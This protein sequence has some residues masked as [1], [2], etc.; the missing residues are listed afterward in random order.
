M[1]LPTYKIN[2]ATRQA[3]DPGLLIF[4]F[5]ILNHQLEKSF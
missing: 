3:R 1:S 5:N 2:E 4:Y